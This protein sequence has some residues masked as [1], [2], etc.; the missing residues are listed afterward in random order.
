MSL[1]AESGGTLIRG[2][3]S[4]GEELRGIPIRSDSP[5]S[6]EQPTGLFRSLRNSLG[7]NTPYLLC[8]VILLMICLLP[9][10]M[11]GKALAADYRCSE[12]D[13]LASVETDGSVH[14]TDQ[15]IFDLTEGESAPERLKWLY[16]G[17]I[18]GAEV[19]I[20]RV[21]MAPV[22]GDGALAGEW[23]EL[24]ETTF[25]LPWR[26]GGGPEHDAW[27]YD[28]FQHTLYAF[29]DAMP[30]RVMFEVVYRVEDAI[31]AFD[32]AADFQ[33]LYVPQDYDVALADVR[34][35]V[36]LPVAA[37]DSVK[38]MENV[39]AW[40]HGPADGE[41]DIRS[42]GTVIFTDPAVEPTMYAKARV[43]FPVEWLTNL[44]EEAR[45][46]NQGTLQ[47]YWTSRY[48]E[49]WVDTDTSQE[50]IRLGLALGL[51]GLSAALLLAAL[52]VWW[53]WGRERPPAFRDDYWMNPPADAMAPA[54]LGRLW[55]WNHESPDDI[56]AT[57]LDMVRRGVLEV[58]DDEL[59]IPAAGEE[60]AKRV[61]SGSAAALAAP[62]AADVGADDAPDA[63]DANAADAANAEQAALDAA[64]LRLLRMVATGGRT[65]SRAKLSALAHEHPRDL[66]EASA[67]WQRR[68]T[69]LVEPYGFFDTASRRA[70]HVVLGP[71]IFLAVIAVAAIIWVSWR[72]GVLALATA[73]AMGVLGN[74]TMRRSPEG[75]DI[76]AHAKALRNWMRDGGWSLEGDKL[77]PDERAALI[78]YAYLF[79]ALKSLGFGASADAEDA[80]AGDAAAAVR[81]E[82]PMAAVA[83]A[84]SGA[85]AVAAP[86]AAAPA[87]ADEAAFLAALAPVFSQSLDEALR[88]AHKRAEVS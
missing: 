29:V 64:T 26:G 66:L 74:Y 78:P 16:D 9:F 43:M 76:A 24:P 88:A 15:R 1:G 41:V 63:P 39:Y 3:E 34:A 70:Q 59:V 57:V 85:P 54:V 8:A 84:A 5:R 44:S 21:R 25:L 33:W 6:A 46:A 72:A 69:A 35:E 68:L 18:E 2:C 11:P 38:V 22:D 19:T 28:K 86:A 20:E 62:R 60:P 82:A 79:G 10:C 7:W 40:G 48:E 14:M 42:D 23:T 56:V 53:R 87:P 31:E 13:L 30:E 51:L 55:R 67:A 71:A 32:D 58:R 61:E 83:A 80:D 45:L 75:N 47:Y 52:I 50:V 37:D 81:G 36:V 27:A 17:F 12:V 77:A 73:A 4:A 49:T 65:L